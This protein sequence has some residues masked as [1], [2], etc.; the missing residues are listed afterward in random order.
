MKSLRFLAFLLIPQWLFLQWVS[1]HSTWIDSWYVNGLY[2]WLSPFTL[3]LTSWVP[4]SVGDMLYIIVLLYLIFRSRHVAKLFRW[5][6]LVRLLGIVS[7][8]L[9]VFHF[10]WG[11]QYHRTPITEKWDVKQT[12]SI[13]ELIGLTNDLIISSNHIH[14]ALVSDSTVAVTVPYNHERILK[15]ATQS[16]QKCYKYP[17][18]NIKASLLSLPLTY[19]GYSG[20]I[21]PFTLEAQVNNKQPKL[22]VLTTAT[23][24]IAHQLGYAAEEEANYVGISVAMN[25]DDPYMRYAGH[26]LAL[27]Y[28]LRSLRKSDMQKYEKALTQINLG[29]L[30]NYREIQGFWAKYQNPLEPVFKKTFDTYL[31]ANNQTAGIASY[32]LVV[33]LLLH[34][35][36]ENQS[37]TSGAPAASNFLAN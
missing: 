32:S 28:C 24:E 7:L 35:H 19:M 29:I 23:H 3:S 15:I 13:K 17:R 21:N 5:K 11:L 16:I 20:Y 2:K 4:F 25:S 34:R 10:Q 27:Q 8:I 18:Q 14:N 31:K 9:A 12:Y 30:K 33:G 6:G 26:T 22:R 36:T 37:T 1:Q